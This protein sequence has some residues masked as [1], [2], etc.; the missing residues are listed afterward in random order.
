MHADTRSRRL[1]QSDRTEL[2]ETP[3]EQ[4]RDLHLRDADPLGDL[5]LAEFFAEAH[6]QHLA[7]L[8][9]DLLDRRGDGQAE[10]DELEVPVLAA[11][12]VGKALLGAAVLLTARSVDRQG[13]VSL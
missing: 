5:R 3:F 6:V 7:L 11:E 13:A 2:L 10:L 1:R 12:R 8:R 4:P 9:R